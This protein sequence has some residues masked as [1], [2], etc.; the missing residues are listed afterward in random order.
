MKARD[1]M[2]R[3][4]HSI[5]SN[6]T[7]LQAVRLMLQHKISGLPVV[8]ANGTLLGIVTEGDFLRRTETATERKRPRWLEFQIGRAHV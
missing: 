4:I 8:D 1:I 2:T 3:R 6:A 7:V 5:E